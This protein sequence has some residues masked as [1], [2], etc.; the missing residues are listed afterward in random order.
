MPTTLRQLNNILLDVRIILNQ[1]DRN[2]RAEITNM[3]TQM[4]SVLVSLPALAEQV[5]DIRSL[6]AL[7]QFGKRVLD[8]LRREITIK[9]EG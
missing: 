7:Y 6:P 5:E 3:K 9:K 4:H 2:P 8:E 1:I